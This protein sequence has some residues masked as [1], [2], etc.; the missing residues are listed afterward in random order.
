MS[1]LRLKTPSSEHPKIQSCFVIPFMAALSINTG[2]WIFKETLLQ[3][4]ISEAGDK[5]EQTEQG[6]KRLDAGF[7][8]N[9]VLRSARLLG[10]T[11]AHNA[12]SSIG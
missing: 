4:Y 12:V 10:Q 8:L 7:Q 2:L 5:G 11:L 9:R 6:C 1:V 3:T